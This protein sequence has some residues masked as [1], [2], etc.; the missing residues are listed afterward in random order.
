MQRL[1]IGSTAGQHYIPD[2][3]L[4]KDLDVFSP[5]KNHDDI[6]QSG[7]RVEPLWHPL[8]ERW[9]PPGT[10]RIATLDELYTIKVS[11]AYWELKNGSW[12]KHMWDIVALRRAGAQ[13]IQD[14]HDDLYKICEGLHGK[15]K[16]DL[17]KD[18]ASFFTPTVPRVFVHDS[19]HE[20]VCY[21]DEPLYRRVLREGSEVAIDMA[22]VWALSFEDQV[23]LYRE[24][25][26]VTALERKVIPAGYK[27]SRRAAYQWALKQMITSFSKGR[28][29]QF[30]VEHYDLF[31]VPDIDYLGL[32]K[33]NLDK[34]VHVEEA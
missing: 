26:Y 15:K 31:R 5:D 33:M 14:F 25:T 4:P 28:S 6:C 21:F 13:I 17:N 11:H 18:V 16:L 7:Q 2:C 1:V 32:H 22:K 24:E 10:D 3:R 20:T 27:I 9:I 12:N 8:L 34:L 23:R 30:L 29:A 19:I